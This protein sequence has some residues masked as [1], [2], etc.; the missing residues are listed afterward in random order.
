MIEWI[1]ILVM[2]EPDNDARVLFM[3]KG[4][5]IRSLAFRRSFSYRSG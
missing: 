4:V 1:Y 2:D 5:V 3:G